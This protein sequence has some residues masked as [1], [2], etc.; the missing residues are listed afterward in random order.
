MMVN[1]VYLVNLKKKVQ[2]IAKMTLKD[3][4]FKV[5]EYSRD[6]NVYSTPFGIVLE[7]VQGSIF[8]SYWD[9]SKKNQKCRYNTKN[10]PACDYCINC[11]QPAERF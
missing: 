3:N 10:D 7:K 8:S 2:E 5:E 6:E 11:G 1:H 9:C 4:D